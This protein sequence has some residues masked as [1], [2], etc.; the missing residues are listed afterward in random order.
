SWNE[1]WMGYPIGPHYSDS[2][3]ID[4]AHRLQGKLF[5]IVGEMDTNVPPE[6]TMRFADAL[7]RANKDF[8][9]LVIPNAGHGMGGAYGQR[10][11]HDYFVK[12]LMEGVKAEAQAKQASVEKTSGVITPVGT[13]TS[14]DL[15]TPALIATD[16]QSSLA[17]ISP[18]ESF[19]SLVR[20]T[21]QDK[22]RSFYSKY[23]DI[24]GLPVVA[25]KDV[26]DQALRRTHDIVSHML[27]GRPD[28]LQ[29]IQKNGMYLIIIGKDQVYTDMPEYSDH[30]NPAFQN[31]RV[32]GTGGKPT[33]FGEENLLSLALDRYDDESIGVHEFCHTIDGALRNIDPTWNARLRE[34]FQNAKE[35]KLYESAYAGSNSGEYWAEICQAYFDCNRINNWNH[36]PIGTR[37]Q[38]KV[39]DPLGYELVR[40]TFR[41]THET[42]WRYRFPRK[43]PIVESPPPKL[44]VDPYYTKFCWAR[45]FTVVGRDASDE[46]LLIANDIIRKLFAYRHDIL[47]ALIASETKLVVLGKQESLANLPEL[48]N[49]A[50][51]RDTTDLVSRFLEYSPQRKLLVV[52]EENLVAT[53]SPDAEQDSHLIY[54]LADAIYKIAGT[55]PIDP[56]WEKRPRNVWQQY[57]LRVDRLDLRLDESLKKLF[58][59]QIATGKWQGTQAIHGRR[60][61]WTNGVVA[62]FDAVGHAQPPVGSPRA[63]RTR[64]DLAAYDLELYE[65]INRAMAYDNHVDWRLR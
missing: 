41:L 48:K 58:E 26:D 32:R 62:Y 59:K 2:S 20:K 14:T 13:S 4:N 3:N 65:L 51:L 47:K 30:P 8:D 38:L 7:I 19:F 15:S 57:E 50:S 11:M 34:T 42:D 31:E 24:C 53:R 43:L 60:E 28:I 61:Y 37:E 9:L 54:L 55:R 17:I 18:P 5:L 12:H 63:I 33:S 49:S 6:S 16:A 45:E 35:K 56:D 39:Y 29:A 36:G 22:A 40:T 64:E 52:G 23:L 46:S 1:Q 27:A 10:R 44:K 21:H 25:S